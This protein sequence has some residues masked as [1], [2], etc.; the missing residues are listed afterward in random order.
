MLTTWWS[1]SP[2]NGGR[3]LSEP[4][5][6]RLEYSEMTNWTVPLMV[7]HP[8]VVMVATIIAKDAIG[9]S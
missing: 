4:R 1:G 8:T 6:Q 3:R 5:R 7:I 2:R 9:I